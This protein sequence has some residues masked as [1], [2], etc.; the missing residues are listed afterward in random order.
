MPD[1]TTE[2]A[3]VETRPEPNGSGP[4]LSA[5]QITSAPRRYEVVDVPE[6]GGRVRVRALS[7]V[8]REE[9]ERE[10]MGAPKIGDS[11]FLPG[12]RARFARLILCDENGNPLFTDPAAVQQ[13][14]L[15]SA[16]ALQ[17]V[18]DVGYRISGLRDKD[19]DQIAKNSAGSRSDTPSSP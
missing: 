4:L 14:N 12:Y 9:F 10:I 18:L 13:L 11:P 7:G 5:S 17:R 2:Q 3:G 19:V 15:T 6:W 16:A 8:E 1:E